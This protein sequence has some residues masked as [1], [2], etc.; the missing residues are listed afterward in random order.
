MMSCTPSSNLQDQSQANLKLAS[1][2]FS[3]VYNEDKIDLVDELFE[4]DYSH[5]GTAGNTW[6]GTDRLKLVVQRVK[7]MFP[8]LKTEVLESSSDNEKVMLLVNYQSDMPAFAKAELKTGKLNFNELF[9]FWIH[10][11][12]IYKG[13][14]VG[15]HFTFIKQASGFNGNQEEAIK[16]LSQFQSSG[17]ET[18]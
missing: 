15:D 3:E 5:T 1:R 13:R 10:E 12:K 14:T 8:N 2:Y 9:I 11:N 4:K 16:I 17:K 7:A 18:D 6:T